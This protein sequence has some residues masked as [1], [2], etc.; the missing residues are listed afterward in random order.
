MLKPECR[1]PDKAFGQEVPVPD[2][3]GAVIRLVAFMGR[4]PAWQTTH[5]Q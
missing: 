5:P 3:A 2:S 1:G 4:N